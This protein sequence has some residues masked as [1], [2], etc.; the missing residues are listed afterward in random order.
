MRRHAEG[1]A[2]D[3]RR[4]SQRNESGPAAEP[5]V[6][7][8]DIPGIEYDEQG[9]PKEKRRRESRPNINATQGN[10]NG[11]ETPGTHESVL[12]PTN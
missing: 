7:T 12:S 2:T 11:K 4:E 10:G 1:E 9:R 8:E 3:P 6:D 5:K